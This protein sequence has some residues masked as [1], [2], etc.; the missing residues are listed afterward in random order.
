[1]FQATRPFMPGYEM[2]FDKKRRLL[3]W[4]WAS[5]RLSTSHNYWLATS[6]PD[7]RPHVMPIWGV[8]LEN[9][10][11]FSTGRRS[12]KS[13]NLKL[14]SS[15]VVCPETASEAVVL[16]GVVREVTDSKLLRRFGAAYKK[17]YDWDMGDL[18]KSKDPIY[19]IQ[20]RVAFGF[21]EDSSGIHGNPTR[22]EIKSQTRKLSAT[23]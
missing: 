20:P 3:P 21:V 7:G 11:Y 13:R 14:N 8:W 10:F 12:R 19:S 22:W 18:E 9:A 16:E 2:M 5:K 6:R 17:K 23:G 4:A 1:M 15:C